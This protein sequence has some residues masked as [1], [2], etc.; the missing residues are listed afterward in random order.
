M[1]ELISATPHTECTLLVEA[2]IRSA[3]ERPLEA[4]RA[5]VSLR[6]REQTTNATESCSTILQQDMSL[7]T[8]GA[9]ISSEDQACLW[10]A[11]KE[12]VRELLAW[13][14]TQSQGV[15]LDEVT[16]TNGTQTEDQNTDRRLMVANPS[17]AQ[18]DDDKD[19]REI[20]TSRQ[21]RK[22]LHIRKGYKRRMRG[23]KTP[24]RETPLDDAA[25]TTDDVLDPLPEQVIVRTHDGELGVL[26]SKQ[27]GRKGYRPDRVKGIGQDPG[28]HRA[29]ARYRSAT[30][31]CRECSALVDLRSARQVAYANEQSDFSTSIACGSRE[32]SNY[33]RP[34]H[35]MGTQRR[36]IAALERT[37][38]LGGLAAHGTRH[39]VRW[40]SCIDEPN[41][42]QMPLH[43][44]GGAMARAEL[45]VE[46]TL[47]QGRRR[48]IIR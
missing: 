31:V 12:A 21:R 18:T 20:A 23:V 48:R 26:L 46:K 5:D 47:E 43:E 3:T 7:V 9:A 38:R 28:T 41:L 42:H 29:L 39:L 10:H 36:M 24:R 45:Q 33:H 27:P 4:T 44:W 32:C 17:L 19:S 14:N 2:T 6:K 1:C 22:R 13:A 11:N 25:L 16:T 34:G 35:F 37:L 8:H 30:V 15:A 40:P